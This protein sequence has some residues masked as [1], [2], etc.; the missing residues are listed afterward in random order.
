MTGYL[1]TNTY[2]ALPDL[3]Y[4][5]L[6]NAIANATDPAR[7]AQLA[8]NQAAWL[9]STNRTGTLLDP[10]SWEGLTDLIELRTP[11]QRIITIPV[12]CA[13]EAAAGFTEQY[14]LPV[15]RSGDSYRVLMAE[16]P[17]AHATN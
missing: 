7:V 9:Q 13:R 12:S 2:P 6:H 17:T 5:I 14:G 16:W 10:A 1:S 8:A 11:D 4:V 15:T 3:T